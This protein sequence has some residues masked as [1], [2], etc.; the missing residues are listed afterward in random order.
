MKQSA[1]RICLLV[2]WLAWPLAAAYDVYV[3][4]KNL[5]GEVKT[6]W[7]VILRV[8][9][10]FGRNLDLAA[11][12]AEGYHVY[13]SSGREVPHW[14]E[15]LPPAD[16]P[17]ND[18]IIFVIP[19]I[20]SGETL[21]YR[22]TNTAKRSTRRKVIDI[23][24]TPHNLIANGG[25]ER[26]DG[27]QPDGFSAPGKRDT[28]VRHSGQASLMLTADRET[29]S[30][31]YATDVSLH[32]GSWYYFGVWSKTRNV[33]RFGYEAGKAAHFQFTYLGPHGT[34][35]GADTFGSV[36]PQCST[37]DWL[38][39]A[40]ESGRDHWGIER[41]ATRA[42]GTRAR[43]GFE[44]EQHR[45]YY[46]EPGQT[47][48]FWW[49]DDVTL[50]EQPEVTVR[51]DLSIKP[52]V[53]DGAFLFTRTP[54]MP[55][56]GLIERENQKPIFPYKTVWVTRPFAHEKLTH[57]DRSALKGQ[58]VSFCLGVYHTREIRD[59]IVR[60]AGAALSGP[61]GAKIPLETLEF[62]PGYLGPNPSRYMPRLNT[63]SGVKPVTLAGNEGVRYFFLTF[64]APRDATPGKYT[65]KVEVLFGGSRVY[66]TI[67]L[68]LRVQDLTLPVLRDIYVGL[69]Y[70]GGLPDVDEML[71]QYARSGFSQ[72][73]WFHDFVPYKKD[74][75]GKTHID[76]EK[77]GVKMQQLLALGITA[78]CGLYTDVQLDDRPK[79]H[80]GRMI[81]IASEEAASQG[82]ASEAA[83]KAVYVRLLKELDSLVKVHPEWPAVIHMNW[84][85]PPPFSEKMG[86]TNEI[87]PDAITT[88]DVQFARLPRIMEYYNMPNFDD[89]ANWAGPE[90]YDYVRKAGK[91]FGLC[92]AADTGEANR[93]QAGMFMIVSGAKYF[94]AWHIRGGHTAGQM[95]YDSERKQTVRGHEMI[96]W[97]GGMD[98][99]KIYRLLQLAIQQAKKT[100]RN[101]TAVRQ[102][103]AYLAGV[104]S[105]FNGD[106][107]DRWSL[108]PYLG[109]AWSWGYERFYDD[110]QERMAKYAAT[111]QGVKWID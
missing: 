64:L 31:R 77:L 74:E 43:L 56:G 66:Q 37:R 86:W 71:Q 82:A 62:L 54:A 79:G 55:L 103:E 101:R 6:D 47:R 18:E 19:K 58:R 41:Y 26:A 2:V 33:G 14:I 102:A 12:Y 3:D 23:V 63:S 27:Q 89:P 24:N 50:I 25:F 52:L 48:G 111:L 7:P 61:G 29:V 51:F 44:L 95:A 110:W 17:G 78:G 75:D 46:M 76:A 28:E 106:H 91:E 88:L 107:K 4:L 84:D 92:G 30:M 105:T 38:K 97:A 5:S 85:E 83:E 59:V 94:H 67:P 98:D 108:E 104:F 96:S 57:F 80:R 9:T 93:Y 109:A 21:R 42:A 99:L 40:F 100:G 60:L 45:H 1:S 15:V 34:Q 36:T 11:I 20:E 69:I 49:L 35:P 70:N 53:K 68:S 73:M 8:Y 39:L 87:L 90:L 13:D 81:R 72:I 16:Q 22:I 65:G 32:E 10:V